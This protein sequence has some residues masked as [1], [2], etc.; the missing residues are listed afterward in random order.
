[1]RILTGAAIVLLLAGCNQ[2]PRTIP[3]TVLYFLEQEPGEEPYRTRMLITP[4]HLRIDDGRQGGDYTLYTR[5]ERTIYS[6][7]A[8]DK[9]VLAIKP[10]QRKP[11]PPIRLVHSDVKEKGEAPTVGG[12]AVARWRLL[13]NG[14][15]CY[16]IHAADGLLPQAVTALRE[17]IETLSFD[18]ARSLSYTPK[19]LQ[20]P[21]H[22]ANNVFAATRY[23]DHG[24]PVRRADMTGRVSELVDYQE[25]F[26][27]DP[28][29][30]TLPESFRKMDIREL[31]AKQ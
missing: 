21:C 28:T 1:M 10:E 22:L 24:L 26:E 27:A 17:F 6:V 5:H 2:V 19:E 25:G 8:E 18:Q 12:K 30:F 4:D 13:T 16:D 9:M 14:V 29:L 7:T 15:A 31:R 11:E 3:A 20:T 23:L